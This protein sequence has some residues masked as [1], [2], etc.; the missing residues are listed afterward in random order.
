MRLLILFLLIIMPLEKAFANDCI[1]EFM[2]KMDQ[3]RNDLKLGQY[4]SSLSKELELNG[5]VGVVSY[6]AAAIKVNKASMIRRYQQSA[7]MQAQKNFLRFIKKSSSNTSGMLTLESC[8]K[9]ISGNN[10][11]IIKLFTPL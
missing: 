9:E 5:K 6:G 2:P 7:R 8:K 3:M 1:Q 11:L 10:I 4:A